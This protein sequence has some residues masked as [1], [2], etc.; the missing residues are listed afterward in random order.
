MV[1]A[2]D[3]ALVVLNEPTAGLDPATRHD[4]VNRLADLAQKRG[5]ALVMISH[6]L[7]DG[8]WPSG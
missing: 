8:A 7:P 6:D 1:L 5:F 3:P 2:L 4:L